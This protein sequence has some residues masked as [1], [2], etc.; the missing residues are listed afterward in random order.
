MAKIEEKAKVG[1]PKLADQELIKESWTNIGSCL[2]VALVM[3]VCGVNVLT[4]K[5]PLDLVSSKQLKGNASEVTKTRVVNVSDDKIKIV[6]I[7]KPT[8]QTKKII[9]PNGK[10]S[11]I[12]PI[13]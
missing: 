6:K 12:I 5:T 10:T 8:R 1:R 3:V 13:N 7:I 4:G 9:R 2:V 11:L